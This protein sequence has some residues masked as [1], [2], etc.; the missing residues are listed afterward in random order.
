MI[1]SMVP[2]SLI[3]FVEP[4]TISSLSVNQFRKKN[5]NAMGSPKPSDQFAICAKAVLLKGGAICHHQT[6]GTE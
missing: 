2:A 4:G 6:E 5:A 3:K 1:E